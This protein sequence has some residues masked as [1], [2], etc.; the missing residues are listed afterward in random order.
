MTDIKNLPKDMVTYMS[1]KVDHLI[2]ERVFV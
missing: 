2:K 1:R